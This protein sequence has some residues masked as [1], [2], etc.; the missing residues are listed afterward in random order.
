LFLYRKRTSNTFVFPYLRSTR[1]FPKPSLGTTQHDCYP[2]I[3]LVTKL[4]LG[5][6]NPLVIPAFGNERRA[7][8][9]PKVPTGRDFAQNVQHAGMTLL[10]YVF[11]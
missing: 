7:R 11:Y 8:T 1:S 2:R 10:V 5:N 9:L 4:Q 6:A 3:T